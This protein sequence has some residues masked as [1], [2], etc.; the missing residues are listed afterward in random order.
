MRQLGATCMALALR[1]SFMFAD[2]EAKPV[3]GVIEYAPQQ[4][5]DRAAPA[6]SAIVIPLRPRLTT[7][8]FASGANVAVALRRAA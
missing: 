8:R 4:M 3:A 6:E 2:R 7:A 5:L 1:A